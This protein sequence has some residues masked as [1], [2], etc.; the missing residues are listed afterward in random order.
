[1]RSIVSTRGFASLLFAGAAAVAAE[2]GGFRL[3]DAEDRPA[4]GVTVT[5][6]GRTGSTTT[7]ADGGF[8]LD[9]NLRPPFD[10]A[11]FDARGALLGIVRVASNA[12]EAR[13]L[14]LAAAPQE[15]VTVRAGIAPSTWA[16][17][18]AAA[19]Q[20]RTKEREQEHP[21]RL[22]GVLSQ[23]PGAGRVEEGQHDAVP[24]LR[25]LS[26]G[27]TLLL[28]DD[29]R[30]TAERRAGP[31]AGYLDPFSFESVEI[32]RGPGSVEHGSDALGGVLHVRTPVP[33]HEAL[34]GRFEFSAGVG[35]PFASAAGEINVPAGAG[36]LL[37][38]AH[39]RG[40]N[41][42]DSPEGLVADSSAQDYGVLVRGA[43]PAGGA[44]LLFGVQVDRGG[45]QGKPAADSDVTATVYPTEASTRLT[46]GA[47][48]GK[49]GAFNALE[50]RAF[51]GGYRLVTDRDTF[52]TA[53]TTR[54]L[55]EAD[56]DANDWSARL[57]ATTL[58]GRVP[59][60]MGV[61]AYG[62]FGLHAIDRQT[63]YDAS[64]AAVATIQS[65]SIDDARSFAGGLFV[66]A[67]F[68][69]I[70]RRLTFTGAARADV[71]TTKNVGGYYGDR[72]TASTAP[73]GY[74]AANVR[75][76]GDWSATLQAAIGFRDPTLSD[77]YFVGTSG[78][79]TAIGNPDLD[80]ETS[81][82]YDLAVRG[83][84]GPA[85]LAAYAYVYRIDDLIERYR[86]DANPAGSA[87]PAPRFY[88]RN[89]GGCEIR[90]L[91]LEGSFTLTPTLEAA[92]GAATVRGE[93]VE[94]GTTPNDIPADRVT[95]SLVQ[96]LRRVWW[97]A[98]VAANDR[99]DEIGPTEAVT[100]GF[101]TLDASVGL[102]VA[103]TIEVRLHGWNLTDATYP[104]SADAAS[105]FAPGRAFALVIAGRF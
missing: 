27:R 28:I 6:V 87:F 91:E 79:G 97:R 82:Q 50:L 48:W 86:D 24:S 75:I 92:L 11:V 25:G 37:F 78:R 13:T 10:L 43:F 81:T 59:M 18:A 77:R 47:D 69:P 54:V 52:A 16:P 31:S 89:R 71:V 45:D 2:D 42:Y 33:T 95:F 7:S 22:A 70:A 64:G 4:A 104:A 41:E 68:P 57:T 83:T 46:F 60:R 38:Q 74:L 51:L 36:A 101:V 14:R 58:A 44:R 84:A 56:V 5:V 26:R 35:V 99:K 85:R 96:T 15:D 1:M 30:V 103:E 8:G 98:T 67:E 73:S 19:T 9:P 80:A 39:A 53:A 12:P 102:R 62:R 72:S 40:F 61:S 3:L 105:E 29:A 63:R 94:D 100:P 88:F 20:Y 32:V 66:E 55:R 90:G 34:G 93:I 17:P 23:V 21:D 49:L 65:V 76:A